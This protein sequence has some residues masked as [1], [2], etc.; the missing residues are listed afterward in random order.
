M[1]TILC[2]VLSV[3]PVSV[4]PAAADSPLVMIPQVRAIRA[5]QPLVIDGRLDD[6]IWRTADRVTGFMQRDPLEGTTPSEST[7]VFVAYDDA[8]I[9]IAARLY[10]SHPDSIVG[11]LGRRDDDANSDRFNVYLDPYHDRRSGVYFGV[12]AAGTLYDGVLLNDDW[13]DNSWD[14][15]WDGRVQVDSLGWT[16]ELRIPYSQLRFHAAPQ[17]VWGVNFSRDIARRHERDYIVYTPKNGSGFVSRFPELVGIT[18]V[19]PPARM[20]ILPYTRARAEFSPHTAGDPFHDGSALS[21]DAG[22]DAKFGIGSNLTLNATVN[23]DFGQVEVD[24]AVVNLSDVETFFQEK[25]PFFIEGSSIFNFGRGG[26]NNYWGFNWNDPEF[27]YTRRI[28]RAPQGSVPDAD[29]LDVPSGSHI[30]GALKLTGKAGSSWN[31][32][33]LSALTS[34]EYAQLDTGG[35]RFRSEV[36]PLASYTVAR[37]QKEFPDGRQGLGLMTTFSARRFDDP[38]LRDEIASGSTALG[39]DGWTFLDRGKTWVV[40]GWMG[41]TDVRGTTTRITALQENAQ[42]YMQRP[43]A[44]TFHL[45]SAATSLAGWAGRVYLNKQKGDWASNS[46]I[47]VISPGFDVNDLGFLW[48]SG[49]VN[50][51]VQAGHSWTKPGRVFRSANT[52]GALFRSWD[53]DGDVTWTGVFQYGNLQL[54][55]YYEMGW[56][57]A[58]NPQTMNDRRTRGGPLSLNK[59]GYQVDVYANSDGRK[60]VVVS[61]SAGTYQSVQDYSAYASAT[62]SLR[63]AS[64]VSLRVGPQYSWE[65]TPVQYVTQYADSTATQTFGNRYVFAGLVANELSASIR[66]NWTFTPKLSLQFYG[67]PLISS[68][69]YADF[70]A[71]AR[72]KTFDFNH[73]N[74]GTSSFD[75]T[76]FTAPAP[77]FNFK[78]L[79]GNAVLRWEYLPGSTLFLVWTQSRE[80]VENT[81]AFRFGPSISRLTRSRPDNIFMVKFTYWWTP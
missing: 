8:A 34:R 12:D 74:D 30:L 67:Q 20:E 60:A 66:L 31:V 69:A 68:G 36:E 64:N 25:R 15:V 19:T 79:R 72:P 28:G 45:D 6:P 16:A 37:V 46:A 49:V 53:W 3:A 18:D 40:T 32:G 58:Y 80:D 35:A 51:H 70:K 29:Y 54:L 73:W 75:S 63:P 41:A 39:V 17:Y 24:P 22:V 11:R 56:S 42:R 77:D 50:A 61:V 7:V 78:S 4:A 57:L 38:R 81:G 23:P 14:G 59:P 47:G 76:T 2:L 71:L 43:D 13:D 9:Y 21:P 44:R 10:D 5:V 62:L 65:R 27:F 48:R 33:A 55:N 52:G 26:S 1:T